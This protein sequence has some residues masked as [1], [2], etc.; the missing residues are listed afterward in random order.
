MKVYFL[1]SISGK[2]QYLK[3]YQKIVE[4]LRSLKVEVIENT[5][6]PTRAY[7]EELSDEKKVEFYKKVLQWINQCDI[8]IAEGSYPSIGIGHEISLAIE[9]GKPVVVLYE[10]NV[11]TSHLL[12]GLHSDKLLV[13]K[14]DF[15]EL[16]DVV[17]EAIDYVSDQVDT[18]FNF[19]VSPKHQHYLDWISR[20]RMVP[21]AVHLR[22]L[23]E[24]DMDTNKEYQADLAGRTKNEKTQIGVAKK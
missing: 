18:R 4:V 9:K 10:K 14:Y 21:R 22:K 11:H 5:L 7:V 6:E 15:D 19:F 2:G 20:N 13:I 24:N 23:L 1:G 3:N 8:L 17:R 12:E 16:G